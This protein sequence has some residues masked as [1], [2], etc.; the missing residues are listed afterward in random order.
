M[1]NLQPFR[2]AKLLARWVLVWFVLSLGVAVASPLVK[3][4]SFTLVCSASGTTRLM[5]NDDDAALATAP[6]TLDCILCAPAVVPPPPAVA[7]FVPVDS[8]SYALQPA[9]AAR[10]A[11]RASVLISARGPPHST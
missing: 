2:Q 4:Q 3:P 6:H 8:L 5:L 9:P 1:R 7:A 10:A 11:W